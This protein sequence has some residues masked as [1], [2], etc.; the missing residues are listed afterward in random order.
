MLCSLA[1]SFAQHS[2][3]EM[4]DIVRLVTGGFGVAGLLYLA[5]QLPPL[6]TQYQLHQT[7]VG[8]AKRY[9]EWRGA[10]GSGPD[11]LDRLEGELIVSRLKRLAGVGV[12]SIVG[13]ALALFPPF[14]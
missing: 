11:V 3:A 14:R 13:I 7:R 2:I 6:L 12:A 10:P 5:R 9:S 1:N 8:G 4:L